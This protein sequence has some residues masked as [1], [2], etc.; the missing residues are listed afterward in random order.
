MSVK[1]CIK[2]AASDSVTCITYRSYQN[3]NC[4]CR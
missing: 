4:T 2:R 1:V 3:S